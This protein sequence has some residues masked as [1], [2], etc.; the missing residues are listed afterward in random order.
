MSDTSLQELLATAKEIEA[1]IK[2]SN[3]PKEV[4]DGERLLKRLE[5]Q[6]ETKLR[7]NADD[8][9]GEWGSAGMGLVDGLT[10]GFADEIGGWAQSLFGDGTYADYRDSLRE[11]FAQARDDNPKSYLAGELGSALN[12]YSLGAGAV[13]LGAKAVGAGQRMANANALVKAGTHGAAESG[14]ATY[15]ANDQNNLDGTLSNSALGAL[16]GTGLQAGLGVTGRFAGTAM[17]ALDTLVS[18][19]ASKG[20]RAVTKA[21]NNDG[22]NTPQQLREVG[23]D[24]AMVA[25]AGPNTQALLRQTAMRQGEGQRRAVEA[26]ERRNR[27]APR[28]VARAIDNA[29]ADVGGV[30]TTSRTK[31]ARIEQAAKAKAD[32]LYRAAYSKPVVKTPELE[33]LLRRPAVRQAMKQAEVDMANSRD[34]IMGRDPDGAGLTPRLLHYTMKAL[35]NKGEVISKGSRDRGAAYFQLRDDIRSELTRQNK[36]FAAAQKLWSDKSSFGRAV[37]D[38]ENAMGN[39]ERLANQVEDYRAM[40]DTDRAAFRIGVGDDLARR[41]EQLPDSVEGTPMGVGNRI[42]K[43]D[44]QKGVIKEIFGAKG[45]KLEEVINNE[46]RFR[47]TSNK[48]KNSVTA[49][50]TADAKEGLA[51]A[52]AEAATNPIVAVVRGFFSYLTGGLNEAGRSAAVDGLL[53]QIDRMS[54]DELRALVTSGKLERMVSNVYD[55]IIT[56]TQLKSGQAAGRMSD[57]I[58][59]DK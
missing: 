12:P 53:K 33:D 1:V 37:K 51:G 50:D 49:R 15:G 54:E 36:E 30:G 8:S 46:A 20:Q 34:P 28:R 16:T 29:T 56:G 52:A 18:S 14:I 45:S 47:G 4:E 44:T 9:Y 39:T 35:G 57:A 27:T 55:S 17:E 23:G 11:E 38:G 26:L 42:I 25:D 22:I 3:D 24:Q 59:V 31:L 13:K 19:Q 48:M 41:V 10:L 40:T 6:I 21:L 32:P 7:E 5:A 58:V 2:S 43:N